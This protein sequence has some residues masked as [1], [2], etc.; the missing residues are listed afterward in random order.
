MV[1]YRVPY[2]PLTVYLGVISQEVEFKMTKKAR[3]MDALQSR[4]KRG[5]NRLLLEEYIPPPLPPTTP[6]NPRQV[7][8]G[9]NHAGSGLD[10]W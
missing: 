2:I 8:T 9:Y 10:S 3:S 1:V 4:E 6:T 5:M 7:G